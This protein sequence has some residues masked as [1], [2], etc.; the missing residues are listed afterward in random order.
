[1]VFHTRPLHLIL[2]LGLLCKVLHQ[3]FLQPLPSH[4]YLNQ[5][6]LL[7][8]IHLGKIGIV[9]GFIPVNLI[10]ITKIV[11]FLKSKGA[12]FINLARTSLHNDASVQEQKNDNVISVLV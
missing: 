7:E 12:C 1:M 4:L 8:L 3:G 11:A 5:E 10:N 6:F 9:V 2:G